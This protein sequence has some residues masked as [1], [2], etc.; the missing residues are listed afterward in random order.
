LLIALAGREA[1]FV[2]VGLFAMAKGSR[3]E[4]Q[5]AELRPLWTV[6]GAD[7]SPKAFPGARLRSWFK[8][9][10]TRRAVPVAPYVY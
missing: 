9:L 8:V 4:Q 3:V 7:E 2:A 1:G 6:H 5:T 10:E